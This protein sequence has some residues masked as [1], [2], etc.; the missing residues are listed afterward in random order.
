MA[1]T[2]IGA[3]AF[4]Q[5]NQPQYSKN[6]FGID[7]MVLR[8]RGPATG[9]TTYLKTLKQGAQYSGFY[10]Q[11]WTT[12]E[13][14]VFVTVTLSYKGLISGVPEPMQVDDAAMQSITRSC[15]TPSNASRDVQFFATTTKY[16][17][18]KNSRPTGPTY[19]VTS[20]GRDPVIFS[21]V[22]KDATGTR[23]YGTA[24]AA[25]V[26]ALYTVPTNLVT[27]F[28]AAPIYGTPFFECEDT[29]TRTFIGS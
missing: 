1:I 25:L 15:S 26:T 14:P 22:I 2:Y 4:V 18:I 12:D 5:Q 3:T 17:Y 23:Y 6:E 9:L 8:F 27:G 7:T 24:P 13:A 16:R 28:S 11:T 21:D 20:S 19:F 10:L 29:V